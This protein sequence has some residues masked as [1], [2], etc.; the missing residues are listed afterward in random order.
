MDVSSAP[1]RLLLL[2]QSPKLSQ[3]LQSYLRARGYQLDCAQDDADILRLALRHK[4]DLILLGVTAPDAAHTAIL[5]SLRV[6]AKT[7]SIPVILLSEDRRDH[8]LQMLTALQLGADDY[9][10]QPADPEEIHLRI[11]NKITFARRQRATVSPTEP[12]KPRLLVVEDD[13]DIANMIRI[14][15]SAYG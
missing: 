2:I 15:F 3:P 10:R 14:V 11:Q 1:F 4:P 7:S 13:F 6:E 9:I 5:R 8:R 12:T